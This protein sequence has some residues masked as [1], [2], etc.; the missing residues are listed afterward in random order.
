MTICKYISTFKHSL[1]ELDLRECYWLKGASL[2]SALQKCRK[3]KSLNVVGCDV[4]KKTI[5][6]VLKLNEHIK[7]LEWSITLSDLY[8]TADAVPI[9]LRD[10]C[11]EFVAHFCRELVDVFAGLDSLTIRF[12]VHPGHLRSEIPFLVIINFGVPVICSGLHL[13]KFKL[14][15]FENR[16]NFNCVEI[17]IEGGGFQFPKSCLNGSEPLCSLK[18]M[19]LGALAY[20]LEYGM[21][22]TFLLPDNPYIQAPFWGDGFKKLE[23]QTS[24]GNMDLGALHLQDS[25]CLSAILGVQSLRYLNLAGLNINCHLLQVI[26]TTSPNLECLNLQDCVGCLEPVSITGSQDMKDFLE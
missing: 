10:D 26:A 24:V 25:A 23:H 1:E 8:S 22:Q 5:C 15:W 17:L 13:K 18:T 12:P 6:S 19:A 11:R 2:S 7:T 16:R 3:L 4:T 14:Q 21:L 20:Q 9:S